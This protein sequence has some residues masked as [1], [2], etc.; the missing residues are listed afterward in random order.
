MS[1]IGKI[2]AAQEPEGTGYQVTYE[3]GDSRRT[4]HFLPQET[5]GERPPHGAGSFHDPDQH[6]TLLDRVDAMLRRQREE[7]P[8]AP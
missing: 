5:P 6:R 7:H 3:L 4:H 8:P 1:K 2:H